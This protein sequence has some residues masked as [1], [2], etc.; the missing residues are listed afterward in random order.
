M[1]VSV[2]LG[3]VTAVDVDGV[4]VN[5]F[6]GVTTPGG[7]TGG[8]DRAMDGTIARLAQ[9]GDL[10]GKLGDVVVVRRPAGEIELEI[11]AI[12]YE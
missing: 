11:T 8:V 12:E 2:W 4:I 9:G 7:A 5:L 10:K 1:R 3:D 6:E